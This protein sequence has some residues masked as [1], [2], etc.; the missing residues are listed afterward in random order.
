MPTLKILLY[1]GIILISVTTALLNY[2]I[3][4]TWIGLF[5]QN[6]YHTQISLKNFYI[7]KNNI[8]Q[9]F[10]VLFGILCVVC[11]G[12][13]L[14]FYFDFV[15]IISNVTTVFLLLIA[16]LVVA[17]FNQTKKLKV[18]L[19]L[20]NRVLRFSFV[21]GLINAIAMFF[22]LYFLIIKNYNFAILLVP[23]LFLAQGCVI[24]ISNLICYP[25]EK[26]IGLN[27]ILKA[28]QK[29]KQYKNLIVI[30]IT[31]SQGK[32][33]T[34]HFLHKILSE[35]F[36]V[37]ITPASF[38]TAMGITKTIL[39]KLNSSHEI[40]IVEMGADRNNDIKKLCKIISPNFSIITSVGSQHLATFKT[41]DNIINTKYQIVQYAKPNVKF[42][43]FL[44]NEICKTYFD[45]AL[46]EKYDIGLNPKNYCQVSN[47][48]VGE[49]TNFCLTIK[50]KTYN[51]STKILG[52]FNVYNIAICVCVALNLGIDI[53]KIKL[54]VEG[55]EA[56]SHRLEKKTLPNG[57]TLIDDSFNSNPDG[58]KQALEVLDN[59][60]KTKIVIT[61]GMVE[62][63]KKQFEANYAFGKNLA[64]VANMV[65]IVNLVNKN[66]LCC[67]LADGGFNTSNIKNFNTFFE[68]YNY[69]YT[70]SDKNHVILI[71][72]DL[73]D[74][75]I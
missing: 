27:Y 33:S 19:K 63:G 44:G 71:E 20:T 75:Y 7:S 28:K 31:G 57:A 48:V 51:F 41:M 45:L 61:P 58:A 64:N 35:K 22:L 13:F 72:N 49:Q 54:A 37:L 53:Q 46:C 16:K 66:A 32:T 69:V 39:Q 42:F 36:N 60:N 15:R 18:P 4:K 30:G 10:Y 47:I 1:L 62:L 50:N 70:K 2:F 40:F 55:L 68:A 5:Q 56:V 3:I 59:F 9:N 12:N 43:T 73:P 14:L 52:R 6:H 8:K 38:N 65:L 25:C 26:L 23:I 11:I 21:F 74:N 17:F 34:K 24:I 29:L 67:G